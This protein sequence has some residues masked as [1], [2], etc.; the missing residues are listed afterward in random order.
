MMRQTLE[1]KVIFVLSVFSE[2]GLFPRVQRMDDAR[3]IAERAIAAKS[4]E[5]NSVGRFLWENPEIAFE[6]HQ[7]HDRLCTFLENEGFNVKRHYVLDTAF[8]A[9]W[10][11][12]CSLNHITSKKENLEGIRQLA[13]ES[14]KAVRYTL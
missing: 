9:E 5:I 12:E 2:A 6:E 13:E 11:G 14:Q 3:T 10:G 7:A 1:K 8:R 4:E